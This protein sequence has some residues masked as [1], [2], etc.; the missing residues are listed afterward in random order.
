MKISIIVSSLTLISF[1]SVAQ[2]SFEK[3]YFVENNNKKTNCLIK[4]IDWKNNPTQFQYKLTP[5]ST[6]RTA[7]I[8]EIKEFGLNDEL[9]YIRAVVKIDKSS[10]EIEELS[11]I[12]S[13]EFEEARLFLKVLVEGNANL[14]VYEAKGNR[15]FFYSTND[16]PFEQLVYKRYILS[17]ERL[18]AIKEERLNKS[19]IAENNQFRQQ[20]Q[21]ALSCKT[22]EA[23]Q[24]LNIKYEQK[25]LLRLFEQYHKCKNSDFKKYVSERRQTDV[26]NVSIRPGIGINQVIMERNFI[27]DPVQGY[28][29]IIFKNS[30]GFNFR[31][32]IDIA[33]IL[34]FNKNKWALIVE[35]TYQIYKD[36]TSVENSIS[37]I[38]YQS[39]DIPLGVRHFFFLSN[40]INVY[41]NAGYVLSLDI[42]S[43]VSISNYRDL[44][45]SNT[46][47]GFLGGGI[48]YKD[49]YGIE[50]RYSTPRNL[51]ADYIL[52]P[53]RHKNISLILSYTLF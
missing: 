51:L 40:N 24:L 49:R 30:P 41:L 33:Y 15:R 36:S 8:E 10:H 47:N 21:L 4:N 32:G 26:F 6:A 48:N 11:V 34:P 22:I 44:E 1:F 16:G 3:G 31:F 45:I 38:D 42:N 29:N 46:D 7:R 37:N 2:I 23:K 20:L 52:P 17:E 35:P 14:Y 13:P 43:S 19:A 18:R 25:Y 53:A 27:I 9:K 12:M 39:I 50:L 5:N 28:K